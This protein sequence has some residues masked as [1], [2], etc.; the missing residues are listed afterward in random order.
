MPKKD[1][2]TPPVED[3]NN[4]SVAADENEPDPIDDDIPE[5]GDV[6]EAAEPERE[7]R[8]QE[9]PAE[10]PYP[11]LSNAERRAQLIKDNRDRIRANADGEAPDPVDADEP[12]E[13]EIDD[14]ED[15]ADDDL[16]SRENGENEQRARPEPDDDPEIELKIDGK[17]V[18]KRQSEVIRLAQTN[19]AADS[20]LSDAK[21]IL[22]AAR[23][24]ASEARGETNPKAADGENQPDTPDGAQPDKD[25]RQRPTIAHDEEKLGSFVER[26]QVGEESDGKDALR[27]YTEYIFEAVQNA[28]PRDSDAEINRKVDEAL[29]LHRENSESDNALKDFR[30]D[31][32]DL[33]EQPLVHDAVLTAVGN[34]MNRHLSAILPEEAMKELSQ[35]PRRTPALYKQLRLKGYELPGYGEVFTTASKTVRN[36]FN[37]KAPSGR[38]DP[39]DADANERARQERINRKRTAQSQ[40]PRTSGG[41]QKTTS[42]PKRKTR[43]DILNEERRRRGFAPVT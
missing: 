12:G 29:A 42:T 13:P 1:N 4:P 31:N 16:D 10:K 15:G 14:V 23:D 17:T 7:E 19:L 30:R 32:A 25:T 40:Q 39:P 38:N 11:M 35:N 22:E 6:V 26:I 43:M 28:N 2:N 34:E 3:E 36:A 18:K 21:A 41:R 9:K 8:A 37:L 33:L 27:E 20:R 5:A 24:M